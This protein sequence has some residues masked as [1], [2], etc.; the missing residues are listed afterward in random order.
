MGHSVKGYEPPKGHPDWSPISENS[1]SENY[2]HGGWEAIK[3]GQ[4]K[5]YSLVDANHRPH[6]TVEVRQNPA[7]KSFGVNQMPKGN[8]FYTQNNMY[9]EGQRSG[10]ISP[11]LSFAEWWRSTQGIPEPEPPPPII[12]QIKGKGNAR[13]AAKYDQYTQDFVKSGNWGRV[14]RDLKNTGLIE[15]N[16]RYFTE[17]EFAEAAKKYGV[18]GVQDVPWEVARQRHIDAGIP[19]DEAFLNWVEGLR[20]GRG[21]LDIPDEPQMAGGGLLKALTKAQKTAKAVKAAETAMQNFT[22]VATPAIR[23]GTRKF[24]APAGGLSVIKEPGGNW[25]GGGVEKGLK[26]LKRGNYDIPQH[27]RD[28]LGIEDMSPQDV[29]LNK[30]VDSNLTN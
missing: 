2:G 13:P 22:D 19:E 4:A 24:D 29:A 20:E 27:I 8:D 9:I 1:G 15:S 3:S 17:P 26:P 21:R 18:M 28:D 14:E 23:S 12:T 7:D 11:D 25:L 10:E 6:V 16:G 30:W 5:V